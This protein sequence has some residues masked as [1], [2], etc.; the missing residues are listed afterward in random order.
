MIHEFEKKI[1]NSRDKLPRESISFL[2]QGAGEIRSGQMLNWKDV[3]MKQEQYK[4]LLREAENR[5]LV[6]QALME[7][8][9][10]APLDWRMLAALVRHLINLGCYLLECCA[11]ALKVP[12]QTPCQDASTKE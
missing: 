1:D 2:K 4:D 6:Q 7:R 11:S 9:R 8:K 10:R 12:V 5:A 3:M